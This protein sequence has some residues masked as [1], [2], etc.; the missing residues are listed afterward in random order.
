VVSLAIYNLSRDDDGELTDTENDI[1]I[2]ISG[3]SEI[4]AKGNDI[5]CAG[6][7]AVVESAVLAITKVAKIRQKIDQKNGYLE[8]KIAYNDLDQKKQN[9]LFIILKTMLFGLD[10]IKKIHSDAIKINFIS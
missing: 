2:V 5:V 8:T 7:S 3:H 4:S 10:E 1:R 9:D 6:I